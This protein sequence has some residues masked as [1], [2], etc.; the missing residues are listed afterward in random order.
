MRLANKVALVTGAAQGIGKGIAE[1]FAQEGADVV[2]NDI[3]GSE[4]AE[5]L[6]KWIR[7]L[8]RRAMVVQADASDRDQVES[9]FAR[10]WDEMGRVDTVSYTHL[11]AHETGRNLVCR[12]LLEKKKKN[13]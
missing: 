5:N 9:M 6:A 4:K 7:G 13:N 1:A 8:G 12:L 2:I 10:A 11:R 3:N